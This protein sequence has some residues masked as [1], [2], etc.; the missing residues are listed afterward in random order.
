M[1]R[2]RA[3]GLFALTVGFAVLLGDFT[4]AAVPQTKK[5][6]RLLR[7]QAAKQA[8][9]IAK[10]TTPVEPITGPV[11]PKDAL[12]L[13]R[14]IDRQIAK[15]LAE[16]KMESSPRCS[17]EEFL[18]RVYLDLTGTIP[19]AE[20]TQAFLDDTNSSKR[21]K[22]IDELL[23][24]PGFGR[25][26]ADIWQAKL[27][28]RESGNRFV[29]REPFAKWL[30]DQFNHNLPWNQFVF[31][32]VSASGTVE[33]NPAVTYFLTNRSVDKLTDGVCQNF[34]G[35]QLACAQCHNHPFAD[36]K[37]TEYW[38]MAQF[39]SKV[40]PDNPR[41][42]NKGGDNTKIGVR[43]LTVRSKTKDFF[44]EGAKT[45][46]AKFLG[47][48][49]PKLTANEPYRPILARWMTAPNNPYFARAIVNRTWAMLFATG[50]VNP[51]D[52]M[53]DGNAA[54]HPE[55]LALL[56]RNFAANGFDLKYLFR[57]ICNSQTYQRSSKP[58]TANEKDD[59]LFSHMT[60]KVMSPEQLYDSLV[61]VTGGTD[62]DRPGRKAKAAGKK[63]PVNGRDG[64]V[65]FFLAGAETS[66]ATEYDA[67]IPQALRLM[68]SRVTGNPALIRQFFTP[69][70]RPATVIERLY[71][72]ALSRRPTAT[73][74]A[75]LTSYVARAATPV[76]A[77]GDILWAILNSSEFT[78]IK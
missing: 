41:N 57:A 37:Q 54:S 49:E 30:E 52:D 45:V 27:L 24:S 5:E 63:G 64:F 65:Q 40:R 2:Y 72:T 51:I 77:Y 33:D 34:L 20:K 70:D 13:T 1:R 8:L 46:H 11:G 43:E 53:H 12:A 22:L 28:P 15:K 68:N 7:K 42:A 23:D 47:G 73:E 60:V 17:D 9:A 67:G 58:I 25:H 35:I 26:L 59:H 69:G 16:A 38:G 39:F 3:L 61:K 18:R 44:P 62:R 19:S 4:D 71:L 48:A 36:Y 6:K 66:H 32:L 76:D 31:K 55:L 14:L 75:R 21:A 56:A 50:I 78:M 29:L 10:S 74:T